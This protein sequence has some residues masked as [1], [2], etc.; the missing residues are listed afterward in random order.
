MED[1]SPNGKWNPQPQYQGH[2]VI[3]GYQGHTFVSG[4]TPPPPQM[5]APPIFRPAPVWTPPPALPQQ[6]SPSSAPP[7]NAPS[8]GWGGQNVSSN[9]YG[10]L[11]LEMDGMIATVRPIPAPASSHTAAAYG[12]KHVQTPVF[13]KP[14]TSSTRTVF[15]LLTGIAWGMC[16]MAVVQ[17]DVSLL[18]S[19]IHR[20]GLDGPL[21]GAMF[22]AYLVFASLFLWAARGKARLPIAAVTVLLL[23]VFYVG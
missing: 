17:A 23:T 9:E 4:A 13:Q 22:V 15:Q 3:H 20:I 1:T 11:R 16:T 8:Q 7:M 18:Q 6:F 21:E 12:V 19:S 5:T 10:N 14:T 2:Q